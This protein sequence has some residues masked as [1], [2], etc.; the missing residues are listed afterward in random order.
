MMGVRMSMLVLMRSS[1][2][3]LVFMGVIM[4]VTGRDPARFMR[5]L[6]VALPSCAIAFVHNGQARYRYQ[7]RRG[8]AALGARSRCIALAESPQLRKGSAISAIIFVKRHLNSLPRFN[9]SPPRLR[10]TF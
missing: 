10:P 4:A 7:P 6:F 3:T 1:L 5:A 8:H 2:L 9:C